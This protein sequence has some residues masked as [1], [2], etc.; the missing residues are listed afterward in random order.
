[1]KII[2]QETLD[3]LW[4]DEYP[5]QQILDFLVEQPGLIAFI[6]DND[7]DKQVLNG[8]FLMYLALEDTR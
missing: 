2:A 7:I 6:L 1:M 8:L 4:R 5:E 3:A